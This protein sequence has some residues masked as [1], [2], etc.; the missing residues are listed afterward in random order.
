[1][2]FGSP[3]AAQRDSAPQLDRYTLP[4]VQPLDRKL[5]ESFVAHI[6]WG[7]SA[8]SSVRYAFVPCDVF[9]GG[10][11]EWETVSRKLV[12][13]ADPRQGNVAWRCLHWGFG[14]PRFLTASH[15]SI[16]GDRGWLVSKQPISGPNHSSRW[17]TQCS[18]A[19][20]TPARRNERWRQMTPAWCKTS[21]RQSH[22]PGPAWS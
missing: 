20:Q 10:N 7:P 9:V 1:M 22:F 11:G 21:F 6:H 12:L 3:C 16:C 15:S 13:D 19:L 5:Q 17:A 4:T 2:L 14:V 18:R 8:R